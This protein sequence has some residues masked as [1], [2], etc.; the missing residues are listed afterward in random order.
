MASVRQSAAAGNSSTS[1]RNVTLGASVRNNTWLYVLS[2]AYGAQTISSVTDGLG[3][4][5]AQIASA[6]PADKT[7]EVWRAPSGTAG[8]VTITV[9]YSA[10]VLNYVFLI[11]V[12]ALGVTPGSSISN[13]VD[14]A[15]ADPISLA[16]LS[17][18]SPG[19][20]FSILGCDSGT[21]TFGDISDGGRVATGW[22]YL[23]VPGGSSA[24]RA[25]A[26]SIDGVDSLAPVIDVSAARASESLTVATYAQAA[27]GSVAGSIFG[28]QVVR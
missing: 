25:L 21:I 2:V 15:S 23:P 12:G 18:T 11:E 26:S 9:T 4:S 13:G 28:G 20:A 24:V 10:A 16:T 6:V 27:G 1:T 17:P 7:F 5:Y 22:G 14:A 3:N 19:I 8:S